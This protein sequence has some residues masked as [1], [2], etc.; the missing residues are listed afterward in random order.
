MDINIKNMVCNRCIMVVKQIFEQAGMTVA[1]IN[2]GMVKIEDELTPVQSDF[3]DRELTKA[4]FEIISDETARLVEQIKTITIEF[5]Y[6]S[7]DIG[8]VNFS[9]YLTSKL[10]KDYGHLS[11]LFSSLAGIT[12]EKYLINLKI[13][14]VKEMLVYDQK[15]LSEIAWEMGYS[16]VAYLSRQFKNITGF[17]PSHF[18]K[19]GKQ[20]RK[21]IDNV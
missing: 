7:E 14:L 18:K 11:T 12:I 3:I 5:V 19:F 8:K 9:S 4:G 21:S 16:S 13:E 17:T 10:N 1:D 6:K 15:T 20:K 2:L